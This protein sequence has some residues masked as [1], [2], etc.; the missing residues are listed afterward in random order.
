MSWTEEISDL[1][2]KRQEEIKRKSKELEKLEKE[3][4][5]EKGRP[6]DQFREKFRQAQHNFQQ[7]GKVSPYKG[8]STSLD[9]QSPAITNLINESVQRSLSSSEGAAA[10]EGNQQDGSS[11]NTNTQQGASSGTT[12]HSA[13]PVPANPVQQMGEDS[14]GPAAQ[15]ITS[16]QIQQKAAAYQNNKYASSF[17]NFDNVYDVYMHRQINKR[18]V[19]LAKALV[20]ADRY[21]KN[22]SIKSDNKEI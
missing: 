1:Q 13:N 16:N 18:L 8:V 21:E 10:S 9:S 17:I 22:L 11:S 14:K 5:R 3:Q 20:L 6:Y 15:T 7:A 12:T 2:K 19:K 4:N